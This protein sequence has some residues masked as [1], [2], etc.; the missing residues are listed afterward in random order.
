MLW[1]REDRTNLLYLTY[2]LHSNA[3]IPEDGKADSCFSNRD[4]ES[5]R[6]RSEGCHQQPPDHRRGREG[7]TG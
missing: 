3:L 6:R 1:E 5:G 4:P 2:V 7:C